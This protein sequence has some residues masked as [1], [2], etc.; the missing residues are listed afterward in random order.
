[1]GRLPEVD[2][3]RFRLT[4]GLV[5]V[6]VVTAAS[7]AVLG[8]VAVARMTDDLLVDQAQA[9]ADSATG[10]LEDR[11]RAKEVFAQLLANDPDLVRAV[12]SRDEQEVAAVVVPMR[13]RLDL[14][15]VAVFDLDG[16]VLLALAP[17]LGEP[18]TALIGAARSGLLTSRL[19][20]TD[21]GLLIEAIAPVK[22]ESGIIG[23]M[24]VGVLLDD[25]SLGELAADDDHEFVV[26]SGG[27]I[28]AST[29][30]SAR[31]QLPPAAHDV[32]G[33][34]RIEMGGVEYVVAADAIQGGMLLVLAP[35]AEVRAAQSDH[36]LSLIVGAV[37]IAIVC[38]AIGVIQARRLSRSIDAV[39][40]AATRIGGGDFDQS[41][42]PS[43]IDEIDDL[44]QVINQL[45]ADVQDRMHELA[46][47]ALH[48]PLTGLANR[49]LFADRLGH[50]LQRR[51][52]EVS[53]LFIDVDDFKEIN[54]TL[55]HGAGDSLLVELGNRLVGLTRRSDTAARLGGD[56]FGILLDDPGIDP[57]AVAE[58]VL[59]GLT[60]PFTTTDNTEITVTVSIGIAVGLA[61]DDA[62]AVLRN[63]DTAMY[64]AKKEG[65]NRCVV[66]ETEMHLDLVERIQLKAELARAID[67]EQLL[68]EYQPIVGFPDLE[69]RGTEALLRWNHPTRGRVPPDTFI[70]LAE[71]SGLIVDIGRWVLHHACAD[72]M[73]WQ[74]P[75]RPIGLSV[76]VSARQFH[77]EA[78]VGDVQDALAVSG[79]DPRLLTVEITETALMND[80]HSAS[81]TTQHLKA[82]G[83]RVSLDDF[84]TGYSSLNY[85]QQFDVDEIKIDKSFITRLSQPGTDPSLLHS[86]IRMAE[87]LDAET[88]A[89]G[90]EDPEQLDTLNDIGVTMG[91]GFYL[92]RPAPA[93]TV[94]TKPTAPYTKPTAPS[95]ARVAAERTAS[96]TTT[97]P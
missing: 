84:G 16:D 69:Q 55:G 92:A 72:A 59:D 23:A 36:R 64:V 76:N 7:I 9:V 82:L 79:L 58:R 52:A 86:V 44:G 4:A 11:R 80:I 42:E 8:E 15:R 90:I 61:A 97:R 48:D 43:G 93:D 73:T 18:S 56:E 5:A 95:T 63:A 28:A 49:T 3:L 96:P 75:G 77:D 83:V 35:A 66:F 38:G 68:L 70:P 13:A 6:A 30:P 12:A 54:D 26:V 47:Q 60:R 1:M 32:S 39:S 31:S 34:P 10:R 78:L 45:A 17:G 29:A 27:L 41:I 74:Q 65:K 25:S 2:S 62:E 21:G 94:Y 40:V 46:H 37:L 51:G 89:E 19:A 88:V 24:S 81:T 67:D 71:E 57:Q 53:V 22:D 85:L 87:A 50:S 91:Q 33:N 14:S 20:A